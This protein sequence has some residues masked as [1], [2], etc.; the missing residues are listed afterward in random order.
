MCCRSSAVPVGLEGATS[1]ASGRGRA[2][3][4]LRRGGRGSRSMVCLPRCGYQG[5]AG[6]EPVSR[7]R[8]G[9]SFASCQMP[10]AGLSGPFRANSQRV[11][12]GRKRSPPAPQPECQQH[13]RVPRRPPQVR[14]ELQ[15]LR[16]QF[17]EPGQRFDPDEHL[18]PQVRRHV[19]EKE[20][21]GHAR[22]HGA[23][24]QAERARA[25]RHARLAGRQRH[26]DPRAQRCA[27]VGEQQRDRQRG[28]HHVV[29]HE[30][31]VTHPG[32]QEQKRGTGP[33]DRATV[34]RSFH[35]QGG[36][37]DEHGPQHPP[38]QHGGRQAVPHLG[39]VAEVQEPTP[40]DAEQVAA[41]EDPVLV[42]GV[43]LARHPADVQP[44]QPAL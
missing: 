41:Q 36:G 33:R 31:R 4:G 22:Q 19:L 9:A 39:R 2:P 37:P 30:V 29:V 7:E 28:Q 16:Q 11:S 8:L 6:R 14:R 25:I 35:A 15:R 24:D 42:C 43:D 21:Q 5:G 10:W 20:Q 13:E 34:C 12:K 17:A 38:P 32:P 23:V 26:E 18:D 44:V 1:R 27:Q 3:H 40:W